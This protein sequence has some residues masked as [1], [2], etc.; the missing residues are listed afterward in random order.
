MTP[1]AV[2]PTKARPTAPTSRT[3]PR[4]APGRR[5]GPGGRPAPPT[6]RVSAPALAGGGTVAVPLGLRVARRAAGISDARFLDRLIRGRVWIVLVGVMLIGLVFLQL[7]LL[8]LNAGIGEN[9]QR[10]QTLEGQNAALR[11]GG[12]RMDAGQ[13]I[14]DIAAREGLV[15]PPAGAR[16]YLKAGGVSPSVAASRITPPGQVTVPAGT[17]TATATPTAPTGPTT[18]TGPTASAGPP[19]P[20]G[21][22]GTAPAAAP[23][24]TAA[25]ATAPAPPTPA[26]ATTSSAGSATE[27]AGSA[28]GGAA[29]APTASTGAG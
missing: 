17:A 19:E 23:A 11:A 14:Q 4:P 28:S 10:A 29:P 27:P 9:L 5:R 22:T 18:P 21:G 15:L 12:S 26:P 7:S 13:R 24:A 2:A 25:T 8:S 3:A 1:P 16:R 20:G 6:L